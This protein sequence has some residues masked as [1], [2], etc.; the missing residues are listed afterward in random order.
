VTVSNFAQVPISAADELPLFDA[1]AAITPG[2][3]PAGMG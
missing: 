3:T 2:V 1:A